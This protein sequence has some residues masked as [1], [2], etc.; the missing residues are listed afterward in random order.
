VYDARDRLVFVVQPDGGIQA[1]RHE[2]R[3]DPG[4]SDP[5]RFEV[6]IDAAGRRRDIRLDGAGAGSVIEYRVA[7]SYTTG[8]ERTNYLYDGLGRLQLLCDPL[9]NP[10]DLAGRD[11][12]HTTLLTYDTLSRVTRRDDPDRGLWTYRFRGDGAPLQQTDGN[13]VTTAFGYDALYGRL[14]TVDW[15][16][17]IC[18]RH[19]HYGDELGTS[20]PPNS[21]GR[22]YRRAGPTS[23]LELAYDT[24][25]RVNQRKTSIGA[26]EEEYTESF[27]YDWRGRVTS[28]TYPD[29]ETIT[30]SYDVMGLDRIA[31]ASRTYM[32]LLDFNAEL[33][34]TRYTFG[35]GEI[36]TRTYHAVTGYL[37]SIQDLK[38][39]SPRR[40]Y[41]YD[42]TGLVSVVRDDPF[43]PDPAA[44]PS[45]DACVQPTTTG[46]LT[47]HPAAQSTGRRLRHDRELI[48]KEGTTIPFPNTSRSHAPAT[49]NPAQSPTNTTAQAT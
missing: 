43:M 9:A 20:A 36:R 28:E 37:R 14:K 23:T 3:I 41:A 16:K 29:D 6:A 26:T 38:L 49:A 24:S 35:N 18:R 12:R 8:I 2:T 1:R 32:D 33:N 46:R 13:G 48:N 42:L 34:P 40:S 39:G 11:P 10:C 27:T 4:R 22:L 7:N 15:S 17:R 25:G 45:R 31:S 44:A 21:I 30:R 19:L 47:T 5:E